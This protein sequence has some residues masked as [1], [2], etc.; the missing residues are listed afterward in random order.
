M[1]ESRSKYGNKPVR[2]GGRR[3]DSTKEGYYSLYYRQLEKDGKIRDLRMQVPF[4]II[5]ACGKQRAVHYV[6]DFVYVDAETG[7]EVVVDVKSPATARKE[8]YVLKK[9][10]MYAF[11]GIVIKEVY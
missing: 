4:E 11:N 1:A 10:M 3:F 7:E 2:I 5:P 6:A 9:K 8:A